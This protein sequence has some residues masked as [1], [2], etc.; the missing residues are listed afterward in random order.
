MVIQIEIFCFEKDM[1]SAVFTLPDL[2][3]LAHS[4]GSAA[5]VGARAVT[6]VCP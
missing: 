6:A 1:K 4:T 3:W 5:F 2:A